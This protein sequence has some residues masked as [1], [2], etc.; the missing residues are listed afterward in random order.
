MEWIGMLWL[1][2]GGIRF[3]LAPNQKRSR[4]KSTEP[5]PSLRPATPA[6]DMP[7]CEIYPLGTPSTQPCSALPLTGVNAGC[8][9]MCIKVVR[10][11]VRG[12]A[13]GICYS[14]TATARFDRQRI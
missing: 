10:P 8:F 13:L 12:Y 7:E 11:T 9:R 2:A 5:F 14:A 3:W 4:E 1:G 6:S